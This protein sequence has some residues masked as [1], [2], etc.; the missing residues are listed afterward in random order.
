MSGMD[1]ADLTLVGLSHRSAPV[2]V[3]ERC[4]VPPEGQ[5]HLLAELRSGG[6][7]RE[8]ALLSTCNRT[9]VLVVGA[10]HQDPAPHVRQRVFAGV[11]DEHVFVHRGVHAVMHLFRVASGL[12]SQVLG[13]SEILA[14]TK[15]AFE[16]ARAAG[17]VGPLLES[18]LRQALAVGKRVR[19]ETELGQGTLSIA[20]VAVDVAHHAFG[21]LGDNR[22]LVVGAGETG[23]LVARHLRSS[24]IASLDFA[25]RTVARAEE[26]AAELGGSGFG[27]EDLGR[28]A[29][30]Y[31]LVVVCVDGD[32]GLLRPSELDR[33]RLRRRDQPMLVIDISVPR[34]VD[35]ELAG[36]EQV[37]LYDIDD[38]Q[39]VVERNRAG[40]GEAS[41][42]SSAIVV[43][44]VHKF[45]ALRT[46]AAFRPAIADLQERFHAAR[47]AVLAE[48]AGERASERELE[49]ARALE[50]RLLDLA[51]G[52]LKEGARRTRSEEEIDREYRRFLERR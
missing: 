17:T 5:A 8:A 52:S 47:D 26:A 27:L 40:R 39:P 50:R 32:G 28:R 44:E 14:Q 37:L 21:N 24:G 20:R 51:L 6:E 1:L 34:A 49:L 25:N 4:A 45:L 18:L 23:L 13:E 33:R 48:V 29:P 2:E 16:T 9:E 10:G 36:L 11:S 35:P 7:V 30:E 46:Y 12:E 15:R 38:L 22:A 43:A 19:S 31:D 3:R 42:V 41:A